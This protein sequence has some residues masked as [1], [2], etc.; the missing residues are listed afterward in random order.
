M[1]YECRKAECQALVARR[2]RLVVTCLRGLMW[3]SAKGNWT[4]VFRKSSSSELIA[5]N[6]LQ[7]I[8]NATRIKAALCNDSRLVYF[9]V[10]DKTASRLIRL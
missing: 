1:I 4:K 3:N 5:A 6:Y 2:R 10:R 9:S 8:V 7:L